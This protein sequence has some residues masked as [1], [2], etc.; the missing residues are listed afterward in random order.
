MILR[1]LTSPVPCSQR[2]INIHGIAYEHDVGGWI[3]HCRAAGNYS[4]IYSACDW[5]ILIVEG[6]ALVPNVSGIANVN[7]IC[8]DILGKGGGFVGCF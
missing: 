4:S 2:A 5:L 8:D 3:A 1:S 7:I 6:N